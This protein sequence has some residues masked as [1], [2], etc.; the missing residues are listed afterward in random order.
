MNMNKMDANAASTKNKLT[1]GRTTDSFRHIANSH[2][3][4]HGASH[5]ASLQIACYSQIV[6][7]VFK[8][9]RHHLHHATCLRWSITTM[10]QF[11]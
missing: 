6:H 5:P 10:L 4:L 1:D 8:F 3:T 9:I 7:V 11:A 2:C